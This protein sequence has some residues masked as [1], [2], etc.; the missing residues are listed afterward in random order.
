MAE[1]ARSADQALD[2]WVTERS[3]L[4]T[5]L[6]YARQRVPRYAVVRA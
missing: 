1:Q 6:R 5:Q 4:L 3:S 2:A